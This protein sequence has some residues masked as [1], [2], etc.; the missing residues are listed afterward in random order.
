MKKLTILIA[1][2]LL[3]ACS[4][5]KSSV[6]ANA[7]STARIGGV[8]TGQCATGTSTANVGTIYDATNP[9]NFENQ[10]KGLLS[11]TTSPY[12]IGT[13]SGQGNA[14][15]G[16]R[17]N[18][19][20]K[21]D[22]AGNVI[23]AQTQIKITVYDSIWQANQTQANLIEI[24]FNTTKGSTIAGQFN[25]ASGDG[26]LSLKDAYGEIRFTGKIDAQNFSGTV[27]YQNT[28]SVLGGTPASGTLGQFFIQRCAILQ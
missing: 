26:Y 12:E 7:T 22:A 16:V 8:T 25:T 21:L 14:A 15:T 5:K 18:G 11:A 24:V 20:L 2:S 9:Y 3:A 17:F 1:L 10:V 4:P 28:T 13:I 27:A 6:K 23:G 19:V